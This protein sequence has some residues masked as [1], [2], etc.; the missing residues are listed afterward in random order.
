MEEIIYKNCKI[1][2]HGSVDQERVKQATQKF[3]CSILRQRTAA[4][5]QEKTA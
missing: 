5:R 2:V 3:A 4:K 1:R